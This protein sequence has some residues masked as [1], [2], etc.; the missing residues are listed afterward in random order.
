MSKKEEILVKALEQLRKLSDSKKEELIKLEQEVENEKENIIEDNE[1][2]EITNNKIKKLEEDKEEYLDCIEI[3]EDFLNGFSKEYRAIKYVLNFNPLLVGPSGEKD[4]ADHIRMLRLYNNLDE[5]HGFM[6]HLG[7]KSGIKYVLKIKHFEG[8]NDAVDDAL[9]YTDLQFDLEKTGFISSLY[10]VHSNVMSYLKTF[11]FNYFFTTVISFLEKTIPNLKKSVEETEIKI[12]NEKNK[13]REQR[14]KEIAI[15]QQDFTDK[16]NNTSNYIKRIEEAIKFYD[17]Y[18]ADPSKENLSKLLDY[19]VEFNVISNRDVKLLEYEE[20]EKPKEEYTPIEDKPIKVIKTKEEMP[21]LDGDYYLRK[22]TQNIICFLGDDKDNFSSDLAALD[23][24]ARKPALKWLVDI[25]N[26][27]YVNKD[28]SF[29]LG[30]PPVSSESNRKTRALLKPPF[31]FNYLRF[32]IK[33]K[34]YRVHA[35]TRYSLLL[36]KLGYGSGNI[37]FF[38]S[39]DINAD[40]KKDDTYSRVGK[41]TI[42]QLGTKKRGM[43]LKPSFDY[44]EHITRGYI[45]VSLLS[46]NDKEKKRLGKFYGYYK[47]IAMTID[48]EGYIYFEVLDQDSINNVTNYLNR[49]FMKQSTTMFDIIRESKTKKGTSYD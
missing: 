32:G 38:G 48:G 18:K 7:A 17:V 28:T 1:P 11:D 29:P 41:R 19:F 30:A 20:I 37:T 12:V 44:I 27:L 21:E 23:N 34:G 39:M 33:D 14:E 35:V 5:F 47:D 3:A 42:E 25:F 10:V 24:S 45:P 43:A 49:Y 4:Y 13:E 26:D 22:Q 46:D 8:Y 16:L 6:V 40:D 9:N 36:D 15:K 2:K 31:G